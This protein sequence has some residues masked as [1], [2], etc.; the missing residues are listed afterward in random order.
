[1]GRLEKLVQRRMADSSLVRAAMIN[2]VYRRIEDSEA[3]QYT[4][5]AMQPVDPEYTKHTV[6]QGNRVRSQLSERLTGKHEF[7]YQGSVTTD[8][9]IRARSDIDLLVIQTRWERMESPQVPTSPYLGDT[10]A[11]MRALR[12]SVESALRAAFPVAVVDTTGSTALSISGGSLTRDVDVVPASWF[13]TNAYAESR[14]KSDRG[15]EVFDKDRSNFIQNRPFLIARLIEERDQL[16]R[17]GLRRAIRLMKSLKYDSDGR[18]TISSFNIVGIAYNIPPTTL[19]SPAPRE[20]MILE[21]CCA[22][23]ER[24]TSDPLLRA[25]IR[26]PDDQRGVF[27]DGQGAS[28]ADLAALTK[29]LV[30]LRND[31]IRSNRRAFRRLDEARIDYG[32]VAS[33]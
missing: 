29:E 17:G 26:V 5:G 12:N 27:G 31:V 14:A 23:C 30:D 19:V 2:E 10:K 25:A 21:A 33:N 11:D 28:A 7:E 16:T 20:L 3:V 15:V 13:N 22:Y 4:V 24:L 6:E 9:H 18:A 8:T 1:M 32:M